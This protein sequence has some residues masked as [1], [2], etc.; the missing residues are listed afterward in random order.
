M[1]VSVN[2]CYELYPQ[3]T[4]S[5]SL[6]VQSHTQALFAKCMRISIKPFFYT[7]AL[8]H[9]GRLYSET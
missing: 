9:Q 8:L 2:G 1:K 7:F 6:H 3:A 5:T 4:V